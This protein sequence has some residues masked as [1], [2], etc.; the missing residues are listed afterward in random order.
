M[1]IAPSTTAP[2]IP[3]ARQRIAETVKLLRAQ[4]ELPLTW[5]APTVAD[6]AAILR[7]HTPQ[8][9][10]RPVLSRKTSM[11]TRPYYDNIGNHARRSVGGALEALAAGA[12][13]RDRLQPHAPRP[14]TTP[15]ASAAWASAT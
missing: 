6:D 11:T 1:N 2:A 8:M 15:P 12:A 14:D 10:A 13:G 4:A 3:S 7:A 9:I 5:A